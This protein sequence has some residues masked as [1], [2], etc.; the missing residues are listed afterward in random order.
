MAD[1]VDIR[2]GR[3]SL[4]KEPRADGSDAEATRSDRDQS[5]W[6]SLSLT[7]LA[8]AQGVTPVEDLE[9]VAALWPS[10]DDP[11][12]MLAYVLADRTARRRVAESDPDR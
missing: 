10:D 8:E 9:G 11:D 5:F 2:D 3:E 6:S 4:R 1:S 7:E 12:D